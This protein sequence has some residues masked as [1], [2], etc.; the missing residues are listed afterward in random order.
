MWAEI[1]GG[2]GEG[3]RYTLVFFSLSI[4]L[5]VK[6][7]PHS[8]S[9]FC[10]HIF[11]LHIIF[12]QSHIFFSLSSTLANL[13]FLIFLFFIA[14]YTYSSTRHHSIFLLC[15]SFHISPIFLL[16]PP[17]VFF[18]FHHPTHSPFLPLSHL[19]LQLV[20][21]NQLTNTRIRRSKKVF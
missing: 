8:P 1:K 14:L 19:S 5:F 7:Y 18:S 15:H 3:G 17:C 13:V 6:L 21:P 16:L 12:S 9:T 10:S 11:A 20:G 2:G 4:V